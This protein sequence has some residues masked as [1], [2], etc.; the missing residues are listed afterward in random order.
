M[1]HCFIIQ[2]P[3]IEPG[4]VVF[5]LEEQDHNK[6]KRKG[7]DLLTTMVTMLENSD[8]IYYYTTLF[9][10]EIDLVESL[11]GFKRVITTLDK[12][13]LLIVSHVGDVITHGKLLSVI[14]YSSAYTLYYT[15][16]CNATH[17]IICNIY[18]AYD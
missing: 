6:F 2:E 18:S 12:R 11:C 8:V 13:S 5:V 16:M 17:I 3:G 14:I 1:Y 10:Q 9:D 7:S 4:D 15:H